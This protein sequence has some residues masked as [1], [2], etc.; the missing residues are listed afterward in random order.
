[1]SAAAKRRWRY[2]PGI[3]T[4]NERGTYSCFVSLGHGKCRRAVL[5]TVAEAKAW[6][7][8]DSKPD[9]LLVEEAAEARSRLPQDV[10]LL[11]AVEFWLEH[12]KA[13]V[14][15]RLSD[16]WEEY[17]SAVKDSLRARTFQSYEAVVRRLSS[18]YGDKPVSFFTRDRIQ[19]FVDEMTKQTR[20][21]TLRSLSPLFSFCV[22]QGYV[23]RNPC[24]FVRRAKVEKRAPAVLSVKRAAALMRFV[25]NYAPRLVPYYAVG[26]F[27]GV[28][29]QELLQ[30]QRADFKNGYIFISEKVAKTGDARSVPVMPNLGAWLAR[31]PFPA[32]G[33]NAT[34]VKRFRASA[35]LRLPQDVLR[36]S[37]ATYLYELKKDAAFVASTM[38]HAGTAVFFSNYRALAAPGDGERF[39]SILPRPT[40]KSHVR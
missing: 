31:F 16:A 9:Q 37:Y 10:S 38:G 8:T 18:R 22:E 39:F 27:A 34:Q 23:E 4:L 13:R 2:G 35:G 3:I 19:A 15:K 12:N 21:F 28:R 24:A 40:G 33:F 25:S 26:L 32:A 20:N 1:M 17:R 7:T 30:I 5:K 36:H 6:I 11:D 29:P 14:Q